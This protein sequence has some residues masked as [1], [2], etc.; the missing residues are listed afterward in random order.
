LLLV[1]TVAADIA[2]T[3]SRT[4][5]AHA[6]CPPRTQFVVGNHRRS[7]PD[8]E[9]ADKADAIVDADPDIIPQD[10]LKK[11]I[12]YAKRN[13]RNTT[14]RADFNTLV[15]TTTLVHVHTLVNTSTFKTS[16]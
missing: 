11:Y 14:T 9:A 6:P 10:L 13:V 1:I 3:L 8:E 7:H 15:D 4:R 5:L 12:L 16:R 2:L